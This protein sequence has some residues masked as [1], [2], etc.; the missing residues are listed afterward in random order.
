MNSALHRQLCLG[1]SQ[2][3][4]PHTRSQCHARQRQDFRP[5]TRNKSGSTVTEKGWVLDCRDTSTGGTD[6]ATSSLSAFLER[7]STICSIST[8][9]PKARID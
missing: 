4:Y 3:K 5:L 8:Q 1:I 2:C 9:C 7:L 6:T